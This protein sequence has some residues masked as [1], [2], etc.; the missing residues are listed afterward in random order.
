VRSRKAWKSVSARRLLSMAGDPPKIEDAIETVA[1][2]VLEG[3]R[4]PPTDLLTLASR[5]GIAAV[6]ADDI[7]GSG[8]LRREEG[9]TFVVY[10]STLSAVRSRF[11]IAHEIAH[12]IV[13]RD[14]RGHFVRKGRE[15]ERLCDMLAAEL[16][17]PRSVFRQ[18]A[19]KAP[20]LQTVFELAKVFGTSLAAT[21]IRCCELGRASVFE[22]EDGMVTWSRGLI[23]TVD[24]SLVEVVRD[25]LGGKPVDQVVYVS[26]R[27]ARGSWRLEG[28]PI[29]RR[30]ALFLLSPTKRE[31]TGSAG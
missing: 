1:A 8:L 9:Q 10:S 21:A 24:A 3:I 12:L 18:H 19:G 27:A 7:P 20:S 23:R 14:Y 28:T 31:A 29:G 30:R 22:V 25:A 16:L 17:M 5:L 4:C 6:Y 15:L 2:R 11:T 26:R 13:D